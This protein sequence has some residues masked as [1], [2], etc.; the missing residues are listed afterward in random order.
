[1]RPDELL[2]TR[3]Q[4]VPALADYL[5]PIATKWARGTALPKR[6]TLGDA[7]QD[8]ALRAALD[9][10][11]GGRVFYRNNKL[12][13][14]L[15]A[16][17]REEE[18]LRT[19]GKLL[20]IEKKESTFQT[21]PT[22]LQRLRLTYP[23]LEPIHQWLVHAPEIERLRSRD[24]EQEEL[25][26]RLLCTVEFLL[27]LKT[28]ITLSKLGS[29]CLN[30]SKILRSGT[31][32]KLL[33]GMLCRY[34]GLEDS[35]ENREISL[36]QFDVIDNPATTTVTLYGPLILIR[37]GR[38]DPWIAQRFDHGEPVTL[39]SYN[40]EG[41]EAVELR[42]A[43]KTV[44]TSENAAPFHELV[45]ENPEALLV[46]TGGYP[47]TAVCRLLHLLQ[48]AD[49]S[50]RHWGDT[51]P[52]GFLIAALIDRHI[53]T[54]LFRCGIE[55]IQRNKTHLKR[56]SGPQRQRARQILETRLDFPFQAELRLTLQLDGWLEQERVLS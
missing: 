49:A 41:V 32:R 13:A 34:L 42:A 7:P 35:Q 56:L 23:G 55:E 26:N 25:L 46:Y 6:M 38:P 36:Q 12:Q 31:P 20:G 43:H 19:L 3:L 47:N 30:D 18:M 24:P 9:R 44:I 15:P 54:S 22:A 27:N 39:N 14:E 16:Q 17:L 1:M 51:D 29:C 52:D 53:R 33:G 40:L 37:N 48:Q 28:P 45:I 11:F 8:P 50:C 21:S 2:R 4:Q 5:R 10:L